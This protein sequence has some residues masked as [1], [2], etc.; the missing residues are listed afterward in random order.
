MSFEE[1]HNLI[2]FQSGTCSSLEETS[3]NAMHRL[4]FST[5]VVGALIFNSQI[6]KNLSHPK[7][8]TFR[9]PV[10]LYGKLT[11]QFECQP[12]IEQCVYTAFKGTV[13]KPRVKYLSSERGKQHIIEHQVLRKMHFR[14]NLM[15]KERGEG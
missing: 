13:E 9:N 3:S 14:G 12:A 4:L 15:W 11:A 8:I 1:W 6:E 2:S 7:N 10:K 5:S